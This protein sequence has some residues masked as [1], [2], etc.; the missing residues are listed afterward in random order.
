[1]D[2][3]TTKKIEYEFS[4]KDNNTASTVSQI[5]KNFDKLGDKAQATV[6]RVNDGKTSMDKFGKEV[7]KTGGKMNYFT[8]SLSSLATGLNNTDVKA[9]KM[10]ASMK[11]VASAN[12]GAISSIDRLGTEIRELSS[13]KQFD[14]ET[15]KRLSKEVKDLGNTLNASKQKVDSTGESLKRMTDKKRVL[16]QSLIRAQMEFGKENAKV[17]QLQSEYNNLSSKIGNVEKAHR[18]ETNVL[19]S[20][21]KKYDQLKAKTKVFDDKAN[22]INKTNSAMK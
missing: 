22:K 19:N 1:M 13:K 6:K 2:N 16:H 5:G 11:D 7:Q 9:D 8:S 21:I 10:K 20:V 3:K 17:K 4:A 15:S 12:K 18:Q 14:V